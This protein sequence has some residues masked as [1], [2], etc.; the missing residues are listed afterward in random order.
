MMSSTHDLTKIR[1]FLILLTTLAIMSCGGGGGT[2]TPPPTP[3]VEPPPPPPIVHNLTVTQAPDRTTAYLNTPAQVE[4]TWEFSTTGSTAARE[5][6]TLSSDPTGVEFDEAEQLV[7][8]GDTVT[9]GMT[10]QCSEVG[11]VDIR[12]TIMMVSSR[13]ETSFTWRVDCQLDPDDQLELNIGFYQGVLLKSF[14][15]R[16]GAENWFVEEVDMAWPHVNPILNHTIS[17]NHNVFIEVNL[18]RRYVVNA[19]ISVVIPNLAEGV[20]SERMLL[21]TVQEVRD[22]GDEQVAYFVRRA[23]YDLSSFNFSSPS[24]MEIEIEPTPEL[25]QLN[26]G[27]N[28]IRVDLSEFQTDEIPEMKFHIIPIRWEKGVPTDIEEFLET[29]MVQVRDLMPV[30]DTAVRIGE[31]LDLTGVEDL[32]VFAVHDRIREIHAEQSNPDEYTHGVYLPGTVDGKTIAP[33][34][35]GVAQLSGRTGLIG[36]TCPDVFAHEIG[37]NFSLRHPIEGFARHPYPDGSIGDE[38]GWLMSERKRVAGDDVQNIMKAAGRVSWRDILIAHQDYGKA[39]RNTILSNPIVA[40]SHPPT[41]AH[42]FDIAEGK[43]FVLVGNHHERDGWTVVHDSAV[44][45]VP[46]PRESAGEHTLLLVHTGSGTELYRTGLPVYG[47]GCG[48][49]EEPG[50][51]SAR[52]PAYHGSGLSVEILDRENRVVFT[53]DMSGVEL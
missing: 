45:R 26:A 30:V 10:Y 17:T 2:T 49:G 41:Q 50:G 44:S 36:T 31:V 43:S 6:Y 35:C 5:R 46:F 39:K 13:T 20:T 47:I 32:S 34:V 21:E 29:E 28:T 38:V 11:V 9:T 42:G 37:H 3:V 23:V 16:L 25:P 4:F 40:A 51:W 48:T 14:T 27:N 15:A 12:I 33:G 18:P 1:G 52:I 22:E 19:D 8:H 24:V 53:H 7:S